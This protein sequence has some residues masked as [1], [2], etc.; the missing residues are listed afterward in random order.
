MHINERCM[1]SSDFGEGILQTID[2]RWIDLGQE[3]QRDVPALGSDPTNRGGLGNAGLLG[4]SWL[5]AYVE[6]LAHVSECR[7]E[8]GARRLCRI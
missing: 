4:H 5:I 2:A 3:R 6:L 1:F 7:L 8:V